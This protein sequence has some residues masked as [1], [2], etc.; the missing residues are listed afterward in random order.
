MVFLACS[1]GYKLNF[2]IM[3]MSFERLSTSW[4]M[5][6]MRSCMCRLKLVGTILSETCDGV[7]RNTAY[8]VN[9]SGQRKAT[10]TEITNPAKVGPTI[11]IQWRRR[12]SMSSSTSSALLGD[13]GVSDCA[14]M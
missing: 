4:S 7:I 9:V 1:D 3:S 2:L 8:D 12:I 5:V 11:H 6:A 10:T 14:C 13:L